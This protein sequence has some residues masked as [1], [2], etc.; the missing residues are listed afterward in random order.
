MKIE[1]LELWAPYELDA[2]GD[3]CKTVAKARQV[4][5]DHRPKDYCGGA[6]TPVGLAIAAGAL[7]EHVEAGASAFGAS[8]AASPEAKE[9]QADTNQTATAVAETAV[10]D[11]KP[12]ATTED[13]PK[14]RSR[15]KTPEKE[16]EAKQDAADEAAEA[17]AKIEG[18]PLTH[19]SVRAEL[20]KYVKAF[21]MEAAQEDGPKLIGML[22][23]GKS[24]VS[25]IPDTQEDLAKVVSGVVEMLTKNPFKRTP[26]EAA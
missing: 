25:D 16:A 1:S 14:T 23:A 21:G 24:K 8:T 2:F 3:F 4:E 20:A 11:L 9:A 12:A 6:L 26:V 5:I 18:A 19:D 15:K 10:A 22:Y 7:K 13:K 17:K